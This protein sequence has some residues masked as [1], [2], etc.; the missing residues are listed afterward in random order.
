MLQFLKRPRTDKMIK[1]INNLIK[2]NR[3]VRRYMVVN[4]F[5]GTLA[6]LA[7]IIAN[8]LVGTNDPRI[9]ILPSIGASFA[10]FVSGSWSAYLSEKSEFRDSFF[11]IEKHMMKGL[12]GTD[13]HNKMK[14]NVFLVSLSNG[15][16][17]LISGLIITSPFFVFNQYSYYISFLFGGIILFY[18]GIFMA[19]IAKENKIIY[20]LKTI[21]TGFI[22]ALFYYVLSLSGF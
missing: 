20:G 12:K 21:L 16:S 5:D 3:I 17:P 1:E 2:S 11:N 14:K 15:L 7:I 9:I 19:K 8:L 6:V 13:I 4:S 22:V 10:M 18:M